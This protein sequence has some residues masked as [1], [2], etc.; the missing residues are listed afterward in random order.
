MRHPQDSHVSRQT[1]RSTSNGRSRLAASLRANEDL[2]LPLIEE[3]S[4]R[5][6]WEEP[7]PGGAHH[8]SEDLAHPAQ[9]EVPDAVSIPQPLPQ[10]PRAGSQPPMP[11]WKMRQRVS[12]ESAG[13]DVA[14]NSRQPVMPTPL[15]GNASESGSRAGLVSTPGPQRRFARSEGVYGADGPRAPHG[16]AQSMYIPQ[17]MPQ[18]RPPVQSHAPTVGAQRTTPPSGW[19]R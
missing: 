6:S 8:R 16:R 3:R 11:A 13:A 2:G 15:G 12:A 5:E 10:R 9:A 19:Y 1:A 18:R 4:E 17:G 14:H 7:S